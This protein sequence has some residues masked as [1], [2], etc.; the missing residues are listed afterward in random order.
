MRI[1]GHTSDQLIALV[2]EGIRAL[3]DKCKIDRTYGYF[4]VFDPTSRSFIL[5]VKIGFPPDEKNAKYLAL[6]QE[7]AMRLASHPEHFASFESRD[8][9]DGKWGGAVRPC[10]STIISFSGL[11]ELADEALM[12]FVAYN[13]RWLR[14]KD[15]LC[16]ATRNPYIG[17]II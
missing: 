17:Q 5:T 16:V 14:K 15:A 12:L 11:P 13:A 9:K 7:K 10:V 2:E 3:V 4:S 1:L 8:E 6:S